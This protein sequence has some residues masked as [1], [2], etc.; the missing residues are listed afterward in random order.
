MIQSIKNDIFNFVLIEYLDI[1]SRINLSKV[2]MGYSFIKRLEPAETFSKMILKCRLKRITRVLQGALN[3]IDNS[4]G[5]TR[6]CMFFHLL[7]HVGS[8]EHILLCRYYPNFRE[9]AFEKCKEFA[10]CGTY[11]SLQGGVP[12]KWAQL[13]RRTSRRS[14]AALEANPL[15]YD[16]RPELNSIIIV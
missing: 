3:N 9:I 6:Y 4:V 11:K 7:K 16:I 14:L 2:L 8:P 10:D 15:I 12:I 5:Y 1:E 13:L